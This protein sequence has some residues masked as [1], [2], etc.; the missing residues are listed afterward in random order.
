M[1][2]RKIIIPAILDKFG[3]KASNSLSFNQMNSFKGM[4]TATHF[5]S[6]K[7]V[8]NSKIKSAND[9]LQKFKFLMED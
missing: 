9:K 3:S 5:K 1:P 7:T 8:E 6:R 4:G 2:K